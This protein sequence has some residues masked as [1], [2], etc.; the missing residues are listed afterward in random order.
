MACK[1][2]LSR[3]VLYLVS[4]IAFILIKRKKKKKRARHE[5]SIM[6]TRREHLKIP[7]LSSF[8]RTTAKQEELITR[9]YMYDNSMITQEQT[10]YI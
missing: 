4:I 2:F 6:F 10:I 9:D 5:P 3:N 7:N 8:S 1:Y